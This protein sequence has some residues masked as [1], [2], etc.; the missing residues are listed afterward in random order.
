MEDWQ[1][2]TE[3]IASEDLNG[4]QIRD[5]VRVAQAAAFA[6]ESVIELSHVQDALEALRMFDS[7]FEKGRQAAE[8]YEDCDEALEMLGL[9][10]K[11]RRA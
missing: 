2:L 9:Q 5:V 11:R 10:R 8:G 7:Q 3:R 1:R 4:R 6:E